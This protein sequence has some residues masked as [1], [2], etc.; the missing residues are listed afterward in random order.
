M[1]NPLDEIVA[2][3]RDREA[4]NHDKLVQATY[5]VYY[6]R[7]DYCNNLQV[8]TQTQTSTFNTLGF[9]CKAMAPHASCKP[10]PLLPDDVERLCNKRCHECSEYVD[11]QVQPPEPDYEYEEPDIIEPAKAKIA[12][13]EAFYEHKMAEGYSYYDEE[14]IAEFYKKRPSIDRYNKLVWAFKSSGLKAGDSL[15]Y[16]IPYEI[17]QEEKKDG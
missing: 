12:D 2:Q 7:E 11:Y 10:Q 13:I 15:D 4:I 9:K 17:L 5:E 14:K 3:V 1:T 6:T 8:T 16:A